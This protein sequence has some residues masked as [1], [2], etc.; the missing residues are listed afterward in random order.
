I[1]VAVDPKVQHGMVG[2]LPWTCVVSV[3]ACDVEYTM[4]PQGVVGKSR[5]IK[6]WCSMTGPSNCR[7]NMKTLCLRNMTEDDDATVVYI[8]RIEVTLAWQKKRVGSTMLTKAL[9]NMDTTRAST[10]TCTLPD[11]DGGRKRAEQDTATP[12][13]HVVVGY[14][15]V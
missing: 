4:L 9:D 3:S 1:F 5:R 7:R 13:Q 6:R 15:V 14:D 11:L 10:F 12:Q 2:T 8:R